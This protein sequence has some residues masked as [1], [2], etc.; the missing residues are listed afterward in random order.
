MIGA[1]SPLADALQGVRILDL[2]RLLPGP[3]LTMV[4]ADLGGDVVKIEDP[5]LGDYMREVPPRKGNLSGRYLAVNRGK[6]SAVLD[7]KT[8]AGRDAMLRMVGSADVVVESFRPGVMDKLG[9]GYQALSAANPGIVLCSISGFGQTGPYVARAGHDIGYLAIAGVLAMGGEADGAPM[10]PGVQIA[11][12]AGGALWGATAILAALVGRHRTGKGAHLDISMTEG[13]LALLAAEVGNLDCGARPTRGQ[14]RL[15]GGQACYSIYRTQD[16]RYLAVGA[17][18]PKF[19]IALNEGI[20]RKPDVSELIE[21]PA[22]QARAKAEIAAIFASKTAAE[23]TQI[24]AHHDCCVELVTEVD[25]LP[26]H[27]LHRAREVFF[28][29]DGGPGVGPVLQVRTPLGTPRSPGPPPRHGEHTRTVLAEFG[30]SE[31]EI[32]QLT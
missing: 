14:E 9:V 8:P 10:M 25:E 13:A 18:E 29:I 27:P 22:G 24:L 11:D 32:A 2:S 16:G 4:L 30:F 26:D 15:N 5:R 31:A 12:L 17:L 28:T 21:P 1:P 20:G 3:F 19:W 7:L 6:R 23:W